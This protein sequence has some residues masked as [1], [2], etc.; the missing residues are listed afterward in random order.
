MTVPLIVDGYNLLF[1]FKRN[2]DHAAREALRNELVRYASLKGRAVFLVFDGSAKGSG[3]SMLDS[4][5][6]VTLLY[7]SGRERADDLIRRL[8]RDRREVVVVTSD[9]ELT[10]SVER[11]GA[12]VLSSHSFLTR[13]EQALESPE[14]SKF[15]EDEPEDSTPA[16]GHRNRPRRSAWLDGL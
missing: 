11:L 10:R 6:G 16:P 1:L 8:V 4:K 12:A 9:R 2:P 3:P 14:P 15:E 7:S 13:L 5:G